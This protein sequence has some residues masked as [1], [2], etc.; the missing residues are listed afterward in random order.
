MRR[1]VAGALFPPLA[2]ALIAFSWATL[3]G[4]ETSPYGR[5]L[6]HEDWKAL[7]L[8]GA[9]CTTLP[10]GISCSPRCSMRAGGT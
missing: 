5:Y 7:G 8:A 9:I 10:A 1:V 2:L 3:L 6:H 4:W